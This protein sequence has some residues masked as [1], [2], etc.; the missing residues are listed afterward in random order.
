[1]PYPPRLTPTE[2]ADAAWLYAG[3]PGLS[4]SALAQAYGVTQ[5]TIRLALKKA[6]V[7]A[8]PRPRQCVT[9]TPSE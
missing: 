6:G 4:V 2:R 9:P 1:M 3:P 8:P 5:P 7:F